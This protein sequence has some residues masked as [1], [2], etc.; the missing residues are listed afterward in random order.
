VTTV[1]LGAGPI[2]ARTNQAH[3]LEARPDELAP[4]NER[5]RPRPLDPWGPRTAVAAVVLLGL[6]TALP[7]GA[8]LGLLVVLALAPVWLGALK[9][10]TGA[11]PVLVLALL[12]LDNGVLLS[13]SAATTR[14]VVAG[15]GI[16][17]ALLFVTA[18][19]GVGVLLWART[20][21]PTSTVAPLYALGALATAAQAAAGSPNAWKFQLALPVTILVLAVVSRLRS[22]AATVTALAVLALVGITN[23]YRS[24]LAFCLLAAGLGLYSARRARPDR[25]VSRLRV[26][27]LLAT[28]LVAGYYAATAALVNGYAGPELQDRSIVEIDRS[29][30]LLTG[31]R[32]EWTATVRLMREQPGG[33]GLG[34]V[35]LPSEVRTA[36]QGLA[37]NGLPPDPARDRFMF[38]G[39]FKLHSVV[40]DLW[41]GYGI[42]GL[43][44]GALCAVLLLSALASALSARRADALASFLVVTAL[45]DLGFGPIYTN[46]PDVAFALGIVLIPRR[47]PVS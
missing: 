29:G 45:W 4:G 8:S 21:L 7:L 10:F 27:A 38:G 33:F 42:A 11:R 14:D 2:E 15:Q 35:P 5:R 22:S 41:A 26:L 12:A 25:R 40:A 17:D 30:S 6:N 3:L 36:K 9:G 23:Q 1:G 19:G 18:F 31:G 37:D 44:L 28:L 43:L 32:P 34:A 16:R 20:Q 47:R 13:W 39:H 46:L 24:Y